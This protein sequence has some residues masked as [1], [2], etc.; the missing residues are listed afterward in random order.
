MF[1]SPTNAYTHSPYFLYKFISGS[2]RFSMRTWVLFSLG[3]TFAVGTPFNEKNHCSICEQRWAAARR[4]GWEQSDPS[5][6]SCSREG[7]ARL[8]RICLLL[9]LLVAT[10]SSLLQSVFFVTV[11]SPDTLYVGAW[12][13]LCTLIPFGYSTMHA[14]TT[15]A[16]VHCII[17]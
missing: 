9:W 14:S 13:V 4:H 5:F 3:V 7:A 10:P 8:L 15:N 1:F 12:R 2:V 11:W 16:S 17:Y 6:V